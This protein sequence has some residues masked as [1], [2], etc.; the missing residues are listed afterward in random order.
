MAMLRKQAAALGHTGR[1]DDAYTL[2]FDTAVT[3]L[4]SGDHSVADEFLAALREFELDEIQLREI[5]VAAVLLHTRADEA[6]IGEA[7]RAL[8]GLPV[9]GAATT[10]MLTCLLLERVIAD[11]YCDHTP[12]RLS[13]L[14]VADATV[15][16]LAGLLEF[17]PQ[18]DCADQRVRTR[19]R[20][21]RADA[22]MTLLADE[23]AIDA[24][25]GELVDSAKRGR[26]GSLQGLV[27]ARA[28]YAY[29]TRGYAERA[30]SLWEQSAMAS[31]EDR[32]FGDTWS[33][34]R[35]RRWLASG[36]GRPYQIGLDMY[37]RALPDRRRVLETVTNSS[38]NALEAVNQSQLGLAY[39]EIRWW[40]IESRITG[41]ATAEGRA[42][43]LQGDIEAAANR[44]T[45]AIDSYV[46]AG[47]AGKAADTAR[48]AQTCVDIS[49]WLATRTRRIQNA[50]V[51]VVAVQASRCE[52]T[53]IL[54][55]VEQLLTLAEKTW[56]FSTVHQPRP[57]FAALR[58][59]ARFGIR[60]PESA[61]DRILAVAAP[62]EAAST[63]RDESICRLLLE[64]YYAVDSRRTDLAEALVPALVTASV[65]HDR[66]WAMLRDLPEDARSPLISTITA[67]GAHDRNIAAALLLNQWGQPAS[68][69]LQLAARRNCGRVL[70]Y[71]IGIPANGYAISDME[72]NAVDA[73]HV[74]IG[75]TEP[76]GFTPDVL[77]AVLRRPASAIMQV[78]YG[79]Q[80]PDATL[81]S[82]P[83]E[84][85][86][87][88]QHAA[89]TAAGPIAALLAATV[90]KLVQIVEDTATSNTIRVRSVRA[91]TEIME[92]VDPL[93][94]RTIAMRV[95]TALR[96]PSI[97]PGEEFER[98]T[99]VL[100]PV[101]V[102]LGGADFEPHGLRCVAAAYRRSRVRVAVDAGLATRL[103]VA[104]GD[105][106]AHGSDRQ[107]HLV[108]DALKDLVLS[109]DSSEA[110]LFMLVH[111]RDP[112][113]RSIGA[114][115]HPMSED[116]ALVLVRDPAEAVR[117]ALARRATELPP[118]LQEVLRHDPD[119]TV[120]LTLQQTLR[121]S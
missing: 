14:V 33:A 90:D 51:E 84:P 74:L 86:T 85:E 30:E 83:G 98:H 93:E 119:R 101:Q 103:S 73:I 80:S 113:I 81:P 52:D 23:C 42:L 31:C 32:Y 10:A 49:H 34:L 63:H 59:L 4:F 76:T 39:D 115:H 109:G 97:A 96:M 29:G 46:R 71:P 44:Y 88:L 6:Q 12:P 106:L 47:R 110:C 41:D 25:F 120:R 65:S 82:T 26:L 69:T 121:D 19:L 21:A 15:D 24:A 53:Q 16:L 100:A 62:A 118:S 8:G 5:T 18:I 9:P 99:D 1:A 107:R 89:A 37:V 22:S 102:D 3:Q 45:N 87:D 111:D 77:A 13:G 72:A 40:L 67:V 68:K 27:L 43:E 55:V 64:T 104:C 60:I 117:R 70:L 48:D 75:V 95:D 58:A 79:D 36:E 114:A 92:L 20:C 116:V 7:I 11:G 17:A 91:L 28:A 54:P 108:A 56:E 94:A 57:E 78:D 61:V 112:A 66:V 35:A 2:L 38:I 50:A 105:I